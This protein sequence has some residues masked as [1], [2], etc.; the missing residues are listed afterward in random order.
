MKLPIF[1][2]VEINLGIFLG[3]PL[4]ETGSQSNVPHSCYFRGFIILTI[5]ITSALFLKIIEYFLG[6]TPFFHIRPHLRHESLYTK[7]DMNLR[8]MKLVM[9]NLH[10]SLFVYLM[11]S[12]LSVVLVHEIILEF[13][14][15][16][17]HQ[18]ARLYKYYHRS[19][20]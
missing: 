13:L 9:H 14:T 17:C 10:P 6:K 12:P 20:L 1:V 19:S 4:L 3:L 8:K 11:A 2:H 16:G 5:C 7:S 15:L 18:N